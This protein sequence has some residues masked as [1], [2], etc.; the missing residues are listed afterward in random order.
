MKFDLII[1]LFFLTILQL[2]TIIISN[3]WPDG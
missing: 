2:L 1:L 3:R